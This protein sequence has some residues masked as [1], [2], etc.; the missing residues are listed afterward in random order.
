MSNPQNYQDQ[1]RDEI[2]D[3]YF[4]PSY[5]SCPPGAQPAIDYMVE[6]EIRLAE[7]T[8]ADMRAEWLSRLVR[9]DEDE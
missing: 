2:A 5:D 6:L 9:D 8:G 3:E 4:A 1:R 7:S